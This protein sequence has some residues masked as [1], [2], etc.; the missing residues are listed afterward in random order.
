[1]ADGSVGE[2]MSES[3]RQGLTVRKGEVMAVGTGV[4]SS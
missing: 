1:M 2:I 4:I 3:E